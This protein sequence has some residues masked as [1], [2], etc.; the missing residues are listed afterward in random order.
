MILENFKKNTFFHLTAYLLMA[1]V[2]VIYLFY[3][4]YYYYYQVGQKVHLVFSAMV[5]KPQ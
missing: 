5:V 4:S 3:F 2:I 1:A